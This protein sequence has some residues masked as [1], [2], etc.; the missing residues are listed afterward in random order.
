MG[1]GDEAAYPPGPRGLETLGFLGRGSAAR[2]LAFLERTARTFG[3]IS[4]FSILG[5]RIFLIDDPALIEDVLVT[6]STSSCVTP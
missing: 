3:P 2:T 4:S 6:R 5:R 1:S